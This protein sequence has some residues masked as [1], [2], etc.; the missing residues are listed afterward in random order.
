MRTQHVHIQRSR[1][2]DQGN[3]IDEEHVNNSGAYEATD[4][5]CDSFLSP[6]P[7]LIRLLSIML[8]GQGHGPDPGVSH[9]EKIYPDPWGNYVSID[10]QRAIDS[11]LCLTTKRLYVLSHALCRMATAELVVFLF[12]PGADKHAQKEPLGRRRQRKVSTTVYLKTYR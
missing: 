3:R 7:L 9:C 2:I 11:Q 4:L 8:R 1:S 5:H 6:I 10:C 12:T